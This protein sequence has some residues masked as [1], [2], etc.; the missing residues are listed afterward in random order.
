MRPRRRETIVVGAIDRERLARLA[1]LP[2]ASYV[3]EFDAHR[4]PPCFFSFP[5]SAPCP[6]SPCS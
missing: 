5:A 4:R 6:I 1:D 2:S 3:L